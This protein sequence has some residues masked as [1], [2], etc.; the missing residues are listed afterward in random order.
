MGSA[1]AQ[2]DGSDNEGSTVTVDVGNT[3]AI[4]LSPN[5][6]AY[7]GQPGSIVTDEASDYNGVELENVGSENITDI[8]FTTSQPSE[9][10]FGSGVSSAY[11]AGNFI[12]IRPSGENTGTAAESDFHFVSRKDFN[13]SNTLSYITEPSSAGEVR[14]G[15]FRVGNEAF[16]WLVTNSQDTSNANGCDGS[17]SSELRV[18]N[19]A[20]TPSATGTVDFSDSNSGAYNATDI[21]EASDNYGRVDNI[22]LAT[23]EGVKNTTMLTWCGDSAQLSADNSTHVIGTRWN[24]EER[25][26]GATGLMSLNTD[27]LNKILTNGAGTDDN[28]LQPGEH[29]TVLTRAAIPNAVAN[30][31]VGSGDLTVK[32]TTTYD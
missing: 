8:Y 16:F 29:F 14:Y 9:R 13:E 6:L 12:Q 5:N 24:P 26:D 27:S 4:D 7:S 23:N 20:H 18:G 19:V 10:P 31:Q 25:E 17:G 30:G 28:E 3:T 15:R 2:A 22:Q 11:D 32:V 1:A 21:G